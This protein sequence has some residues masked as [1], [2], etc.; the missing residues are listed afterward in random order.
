MYNRNRTILYA[1]LLIGVVT[2]TGDIV[3]PY[4]ASIRTLV[5][6]DGNCRWD[7]STVRGCLLILGL[8]RDNSLTGDISLDLASSKSKVPAILLF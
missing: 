2:G 5:T 7:L 6:P 3:A 8:L 4:V 1:L